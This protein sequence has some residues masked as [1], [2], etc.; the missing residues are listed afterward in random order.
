MRA[1][2]LSTTHWLFTMQLHLWVL[3][4]LLLLYWH[5]NNTTEYLDAFV[6]CALIIFFL[7]IFSWNFSAIPITDDADD[8]DDD[9]DD[10]E[11]FICFCFILDFFLRFHGINNDIASFFKDL[12]IT[13]LMISSCF[14]F[15]SISS[16]QGKILNLFPTSTLATIF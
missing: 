11:F 2:S 12:T 6:K 13:F 16:R 1:F 14:L 8:H 7:T 9:D 10:L 3:Q 5:D 4:L 15:H